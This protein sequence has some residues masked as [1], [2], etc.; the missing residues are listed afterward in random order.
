MPLEYLRN[1]WIESGQKGHSRCLLL[2]HNLGSFVVTE[3]QNKSKHLQTLSGVSPL[4]Y[5]I[6]NLLWDVINYQAPLWI[7]VI[8]MFAFGIDEL[9]TTT[10]DVVGG[11]ITLLVVFGPAAA[12]FTYCVSFMFSSPSFCN[13]IVVICGFIFALGGTIASFLLWFFGNGQFQDFSDDYIFR[14]DSPLAPKEDMINASFILKWIL[15]ILFPSFCLGNGLFYAIQMSDAQHLIPGGS[16]ITTVWHQNVLLFEV[17]CL[18]GQSILYLGLTIMIDEV[19]NNPKAMMVWRKI[20]RLV[21]CRPFL[22]SE[23]NIACTSIAEDDDV[24]CEEERVLRGDADQDTIV[25]NKISK[26]YDNGKVA[27]NN[28]C[29][30]IPRGECFA[31][32]GVNGA[33]KTTLMEI[34]TTA[35][36]PSS[37]SSTM[38][39]VSLFTHPKQARSRIGYCPQVRLTF[40]G[41]IQLR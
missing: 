38:S 9:T 28:L 17:I 32:L 12:S 10:N 24:Q 21:T 20:A 33:G 29:L 13:V 39:G 25:L 3:K 15:R 30:G 23:V 16:T 8:L 14:E 41:M 11:V 2:T 22:K 36:P 26:V 5:W 34:L 27:V 37:G 4:A 6:S 40:V 31:L 19:N 35:L 1:H 7:T 18:I